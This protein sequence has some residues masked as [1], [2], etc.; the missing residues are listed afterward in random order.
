MLIAVLFCCYH[1]MNYCTT[2]LYR[3]VIPGAGSLH[4]PLSTPAEVPSTFE[5]VLPVFK[6]AVNGHLKRALDYYVLDGKYISCSHHT[7]ILHTVLSN[8]SGD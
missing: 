6:L 4:P 8:S 7:D 5:G 3:F 1:A 2:T